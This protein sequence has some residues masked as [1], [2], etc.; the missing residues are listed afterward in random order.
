MS[1]RT[2]PRWRF[3][4]LTAPKDVDEVRILR[5]QRRQAHA[6]VSIPG[7]FKLLQDFLNG[8]FICCH[9]YP[10]GKLPPNPITFR[11]RSAKE[12]PV[13]ETS[14]RTGLNN[15]LPA[16]MPQAAHDAQWR[17]LSRRLN[18]DQR[19]TVYSWATRP[20]PSESPVVRGRLVQYKGCSQHL[21]WGA[22]GFGCTSPV[23]FDNTS[24]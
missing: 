16:E 11:H 24:K 10:P 20:I 3:A 14:Q 2:R 12:K 23:I 17:N 4:R 9:D 18:R 22:C 21:S 15:G 6:V 13:W 5:K 19:R 7:R 1:P 8:S